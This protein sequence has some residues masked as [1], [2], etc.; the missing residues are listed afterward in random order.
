MSLDGFV[1]V[2][3]SNAA[4]TPNF[5]GQNLQPNS[6]RNA[7]AASGSLFIAAIRSGVSG[8]GSTRAK[9]NS[10]IFTSSRPALRCMTLMRPGSTATS[11]VRRTKSG[12]QLSPINIKDAELWRLSALTSSKLSWPTS[13]SEAALF[14]IFIDPTSTPLSVM[15]RISK[16]RDV[17]GA[18][19]IANPNSK[20]FIGRGKKFAQRIFLRPNR[21]HLGGPPSQST[22]CTAFSAM[23]MK[24]YWMWRFARH[25]L[26]PA[27]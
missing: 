26:F 7:F 27:R 23:P 13:T 22:D 12:V 25:V 1:A 21:F 16:S 5:V 10:P 15:S 14:D 18:K 2:D 20:P 6:T 17:V 3:R 4:Y 24:Y 9:A 8:A 19:R 11:G